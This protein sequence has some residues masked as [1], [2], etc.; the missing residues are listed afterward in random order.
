MLQGP[1]SKVDF[2]ERQYTEFAE[3]DTFQFYSLNKSKLQQ[4]NSVIES[5]K[6]RLYW[7]P[8]GDYESMNLRTA[9]LTEVFCEYYLQTMPEPIDRQSLT[10]RLKNGEILSHKSLK[11]FAPYAGN[12]PDVLLG[13]LDLEKTKND[14]FIFDE[15]EKLENHLNVKINIRF[16]NEAQ[17]MYGEISALDVEEIQLGEPRALDI[18]KDFSKFFRD[19]SNLSQP[20]ISCLLFH[21]LQS[22]LAQVLPE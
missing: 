3:S 4:S 10:N 2:S 6:S 19:T 11:T 20:V 8:K 22:Y 15:I 5:R 1:L 17:T 16:F 21:T 12:S 13:T 7:A 14:L 9:T 18:K